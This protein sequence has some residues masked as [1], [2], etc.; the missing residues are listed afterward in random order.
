MM[1][2]FI[3][4]LVT[5]SLLTGCSVFGIR[6]GYEHPP[7]VLVGILS[8]QI[9]MRRYA[10][11]L[12]VETRVDIPDYDE[13]RNAAFRPLFDYISGA[14]RTNESVAMTAPAEAAFTSEKVSMT[15]PVET[16]RAGTGG[17]RMRFFLPAEFTL[18]TAP[19]PIDP[20]VHLI[21]VAGQL[22]AVLRF[23]GFASEDAIAKKTKA[24]LRALD[25]STWRA[26]SEPVTYLYDPPWTIPFFRRNEIVIPVFPTSS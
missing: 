3:L 23:S 18:E 17:M 12:A 6:S 4:I 10:P 11:R 7:Y 16:S 2:R 25:Q 8:D 20:R 21:E 9:E 22:Q 24:L 13:G 15:A 14:N 19:Q 1:A 5:T 26:A